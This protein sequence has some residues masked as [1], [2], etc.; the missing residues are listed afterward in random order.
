VI[1]T[2]AAAAV[3]ALAVGATAGWQV[4]GWRHAKAAAEV[5]QHM[6]T[7][8]EQAIHTALVETARR[9][10]AQQEAARHATKQATQARAAAADAADLAA[11][12][13]D[14]AT[15]A[16]DRA[17]TD[18]AVAADGPAKR[19][20]DVLSAATAELGAV[21]AA[22]DRAIIAGQACERAYDDLTVR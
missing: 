8:R 13:R 14:E 3:V 9:L 6:A 5:A 20:A 19:L 7:E 11:R 12:L 1:Y 4:Q 21:A 15:A 10:D 17:C 2:H 16:A 18:P 22:A